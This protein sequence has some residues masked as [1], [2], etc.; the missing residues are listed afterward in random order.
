MA[1]AILQEYKKLKIMSINNITI[2]IQGPLNK[3]SLDNIE[4]Y[5]LKYGKIIVSHWSDDNKEL[6]KRLS[7]LEKKY[8]H[9]S[10]V[11]LKDQPPM[12]PDYRL[13]QLYT[14]FAGLKK[15]NTPY[16]VK[17]RSDEMWV[18][19]QPLI[20]EFLKDDTK[21]VTSNIF[22]KPTY[23]VYHISDH[24]MIAQTNFFKEGMRK[25]FSKL[26]AKDFYFRHKDITIDVAAVACETIFG[27][28]FLY[29][30]H[31][32]NIPQSEN[33]FKE[34]FACIDVNEI[35][36]YV[37][38]WNNNNKTFEKPNGVLYNGEE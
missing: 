9:L 27:R 13:H 6:C 25:F 30:K 23:D 3:T 10:S 14:T 35:D 38:K 16:V 31:G 36:E 11:S 29:G 34:D 7:T 4:N 18:N 22:Y 5:Y 37:L 33:A 24:L 17:V 26:N 21:M 2:L 19:L 20:K 1:V 32:F 15:C 12:H 28:M 8:T